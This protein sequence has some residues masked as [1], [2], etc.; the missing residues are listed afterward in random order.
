[1][2]SDPTLDPELEAA[3]RYQVGVF[4]HLDIVLALTAALFYGQ[5]CRYVLCILL[6]IATAIGVY[7]MV[8]AKAIK[9]LR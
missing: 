4:C 5:C 1:M 2:S 9:I 8:F 6:I 7:L 3:G